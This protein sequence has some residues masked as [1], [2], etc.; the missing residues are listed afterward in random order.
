[1]AAEAKEGGA[2][3][4]AGPK[5]QGIA[6]LFSL[7]RSRNVI[8]T[9]AIFAGLA[10]AIWRA[11]TLYMERRDIID[12]AKSAA[13]DMARDAVEGTDRSLDTADLLAEDTRNYIASKGGLGAIPPDDLHAY[14]ARRTKVTSVPDYLMVVDK[15]GM[16]VVM[17]ERTN[18]PRISLSDRDW[19]KAH[20]AQDIDSYVGPAIKSRLGRNVLYTFSKTIYGADGFAGVVDVGISAPHV[21]DPAERP[22]GQ[23]LKQV[24]SK[25]GR[26]I[27]SNFMAFGPTGNPIPQTAPFNGVLPQPSGFLKS[28]NP[29]LLIGYRED[30]GRDLIAT[31]TLHRS[32]ILARWDDDV[33]VGFVLFALAI[34]VGGLLAKLAADLAETDLR[35]RRAIEDTVSA[36]SAAV[37]QRDHLLKEIHHRVKNNLQLTSSLIQIQSREFENPSVR[38]AFKET[39]QR[40]YAIGM[41]HDVLYHD[42][43]KVSIDMNGYLTR[44]SAEIARANEAINR[45]IR[46]ELRVDPIELMPEQA[47]PLG[48]VTSEVLIN[49]YKQA[50]PPDKGGLISIGL[51][52]ADGDVELTISSNGKGHELKDGTVLGGRLV[53]TLSTQLRGSYSFDEAQNGAFRLIFRKSKIRTLDPTPEDASA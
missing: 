31:V 2:G 26:L 24:W 20:A 1:M 3:S 48:L 8:Y 29:D 39:Q 14:L 22:P 45:G 21:R 52:E 32:E 5:G 37:S 43:T 13:L 9:L 28:S 46:T 36:L 47:T 41:I 51:H 35:A 40:L 49:A 23:P 15:T 10:L 33:K 16:P 11:N 18:V 50:F 7:R 53:R 34:L 6:G 19:F 44:L 30:A 38:D 4:A 27:L 42:D 17:S 25:G 12:G